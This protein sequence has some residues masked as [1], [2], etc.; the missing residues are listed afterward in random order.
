MTNQSSAAT[1]PWR[2]LRLAVTLVVGV[3]IWFAP[4]PEGLSQEAWHLF[5]LFITSIIA[6]LV[7]AA[8]IL[9]AS[10]VALAAA[11]LTGTLP[12]I[13]AFS[14]F[15][16]D[17]ILLIIVAFL[18]AR[19]VVKSGLGKRV[20][21]LIIARFGRST[22]GL[23]YSIMATDAILAPAFPSN[24]AR[25]GV[26]YPIILS[27]A[28]DSDSTVEDGTARRVG[29]YLMMQGIASLTISSGLWLTA[30]AGNPAAAQIARG[31]GVEIGFGSWLVASS[32]PSLVAIVVLPYVLYRVF[33][34][35]L[36][37]TPGAPAAAREQL[38][39][40]GRMSRDEW[41]TAVTFLSMLILWAIPT[42]N[43][44]AV[45][46]LGLAVL[47]ATNIY[48]LEDLRHEGEALG[49]LIW[50]AALYALSTYLNEF[51]FMAF[52]GERVAA[53]L[54]GLS[55]PIVYVA[56]VVA[57][58]MLHYLFVS[59]LAHLLAL[60]GVFLSVGVEAGVPATLLAFMLL[61]ANNFFAAITPQGSSA[62]VVFVGSG[63][64]SVSEVYKYGA[65]VTFVNLV[66]YLAVGTPWILLLGFFD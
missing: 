54:D 29:S 12:A 6:V 36:K 38:A 58:C 7:G 53:R 18:V 52:V 2:H 51:G 65:V 27:L 13:D 35:E 30:M 28:R 42:V 1:K 49:V 62:N 16:Q 64:L 43:N 15:S 19:G 66:I 24:T 33:P 17:F 8:P 61:F 48:A 39:R 4:V 37:Q 40:M 59:Q 26:L 63:Y 55:W 23:G 9:L 31:F 47:M 20:A 14:G 25:S 57:Y 50:F 32:L 46:F 56:L 3:A 21:Y 5:A 44:T 22:L 60:L 11:V 41:I 10:M 34:P 45:A